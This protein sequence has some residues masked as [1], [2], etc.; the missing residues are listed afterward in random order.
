MLVFS[1][2]KNVFFGGVYISL[3]SSFHH[4]NRK[5]TQQQSQ[6]A[7]TKV[8]NAALQLVDPSIFTLP[9][10]SSCFYNYCVII[11]CA[12]HNTSPTSTGNIQDKSTHHAAHAHVSW[13]WLGHRFN[14]KSIAHT[15]VLTRAF[16]VIEPFW[17]TLLVQSGCFHELSSEHLQLVQ[18]DNPKTT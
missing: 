11:P 6:L 10:D 18:R 13:E 1:A 14:G 4:Q 9:S 17:S 3:C 8:L 2:A 7:K 16:Q 5:P 12:N 15:Q